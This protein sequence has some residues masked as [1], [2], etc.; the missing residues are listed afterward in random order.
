MYEDHH[1]R[2]LHIL[3]KLPYRL[4]NDY[5]A[6]YGRLESSYLQSHLAISLTF[7]SSFSK[8]IHTIFILLNNA[9]LKSSNPVTTEETFAILTRI[10]DEYPEYIIVLPISVEDYLS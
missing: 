8:T 1:D 5:Y 10:L 7:R 9:Y 3:M 6:E 4:C 2:D